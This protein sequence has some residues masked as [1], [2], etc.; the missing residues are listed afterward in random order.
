MPIRVL[1]VDDDADIC[2]PITKILEGF[3]VV[4]VIGIE[5]AYRR[6]R[7]DKFDLILIDFHLSDG[8]G[9]ELCNCIR[10]T[11]KT[12]PIVFVTDAPWITETEAIHVGAQGLIKKDSSYFAACLRKKVELLTGVER[13]GFT[14]IE[15]QSV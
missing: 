11:D 7:E 12:I 6:F 3:E 10:L 13:I 1:C 5:N 4:S 9:F 14:F 8:S 15:L 2:V